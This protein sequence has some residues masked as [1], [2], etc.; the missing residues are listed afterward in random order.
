MVVPSPCS[1]WVGSG[2]IGG[3]GDDSDV[4]GGKDCDD[5]NT[6]QH[7]HL[8]QYPRLLESQRSARTTLQPFRRA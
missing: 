4:Y 1:G 7:Q 3:C 8:N 6:Q 5:E 2:S